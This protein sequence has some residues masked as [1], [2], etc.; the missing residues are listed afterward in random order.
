MGEVKI[1]EKQE[2]NEL[3]TRKVENLNLK[4]KGWKIVENFDIQ[5]YRYINQCKRFEALFLMS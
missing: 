4:E 3:K 2:K 1:Q 5:L